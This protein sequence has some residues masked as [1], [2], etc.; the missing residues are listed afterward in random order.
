MKFDYFKKIGPLLSTI[1]MVIFLSLL[2]WVFSGIYV[3]KADQAGVIRRFGKMMPLAVKPGIHYHFPYPIDSVTRLPLTKVH[4][5]AIGFD[6]KIKDERDLFSQEQSEFLTGDENIIHCRLLV[7]WSISDPIAYITSIENP[8]ELLVYLTENTL[9]TKL[10]ITSVDDALTRNRVQITNNV[11]QEL[12]WQLSIMNVGISVVA[13]DLNSMSPP[14]SVANAFKEVASAREDAARMIHVAQGYQNEAKPKSLGDARSM[15]T[16]ARAHEEKVVNT[17]TGDAQRFTLLLKE[18]R[19]SP[20]LTRQRLWLETMEKTYPR[21]I[22]YMLG[23]KA[24]EKASSVTLFMD[25][26]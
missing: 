22:K 24:A 9:M 15:I 26:L 1:Q 7:Q 20:S 10:G 23:T 18:Y 2:M 13:V 14:A 16:L 21:M 6:P 19:K 12:D 3:I 4:S 25:E 8:N 11:K 17:A 5:L